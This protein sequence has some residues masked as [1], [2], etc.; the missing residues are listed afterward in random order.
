MGGHWPTAPKVVGSGISSQVHLLCQECNVF[1][2]L[3]YSLLS[4]SHHLLVAPTGHHPATEVAH[5][6]VRVVDEHLV[7]VMVMVMVTVMVMVI[8]NS[9]L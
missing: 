6:L 7:M 9:I 2:K 1:R 8:I 3:D 5:T 4:Y